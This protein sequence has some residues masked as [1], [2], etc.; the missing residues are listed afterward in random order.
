M[1]VKTNRMM[2]AT[3]KV[4]GRNEW[5]IMAVKGRNVDEALG[6]AIRLYGIDAVARVYD[7]FTGDSWDSPLVMAN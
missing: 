4:F 3:I 5:R 2:E 1:T 6:K 7:P